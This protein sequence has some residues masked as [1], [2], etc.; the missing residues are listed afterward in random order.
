MSLRDYEVPRDNFLYDT[1]G[2]VVGV[3][4]F[5][6]CCCEHNMTDVR[7]EPCRTCDHNAN[8]VPDNPPNPQVSGSRT[9][10]QKGIES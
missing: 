2:R 3:F 10:S 4:S 8:A 5:P 9:A 1:K 7:K 6:C